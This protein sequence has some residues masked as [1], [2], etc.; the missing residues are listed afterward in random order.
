[1]EV[2]ALADCTLHLF[3]TK[4][5]GMVARHCLLKPISYVGRFS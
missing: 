1:M 5:T 4:D 2:M 3:Q